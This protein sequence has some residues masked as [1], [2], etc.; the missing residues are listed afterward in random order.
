MT[1]WVQ[2][3]WKLIELG[4]LATSVARILLLWNGGMGI[5]R[6]IC[7][8]SV[9]VCSEINK[10]DPVSNRDDKDWHLRVFF[11]LHTQ[12][13][14]LLYLQ[15]LT[16]TSIHLDSHTHTTATTNNK[17]SNNTVKR[18]NWARCPDCRRYNLLQSRCWH[19]LKGWKEC[20]AA[21]LWI[22]ILVWFYIVLKDFRKDRFSGGIFS[23][24]WQAYLVW[25]S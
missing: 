17:N 12:I 23:G 1:I 11:D 25:F 21:N 5:P 9:V 6:S 15:S 20:P 16:W 7:G 4:R 18:K 22:Y 24:D 13:V 10:K 19:T 14:T 8:N 3:P 2:N